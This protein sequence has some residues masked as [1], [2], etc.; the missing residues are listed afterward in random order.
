[1]DY[2]PFAPA[3]VAVVVSLRRHD[4]NIGIMKPMMRRRSWIQ[5]MSRRIRSPE[6]AELFVNFTI[7][8]ITERSWIV[9]SLFVPALDLVCNYS[10]LFQSKS[11][12]QHPDLRC[13]RR[14][15]QSLV[16]NSTNDLMPQRAVSKNRSGELDAN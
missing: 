3:S 7:G 16:C 14:V 1:M 6:I 4:G 8:G 15:R 13:G 12:E 9:H 10:G 5:I 2:V 11:V